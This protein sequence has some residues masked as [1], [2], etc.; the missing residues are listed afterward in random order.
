MI[1]AGADHVVVPFRGAD[2]SRGYGAAVY[3]DT[4][5]HIGGRG[6]LERTVGS[7]KKE[8]NREYQTRASRSNAKRQIFVACSESIPGMGQTTVIPSE[9]IRVQL[10]DWIRPFILWSSS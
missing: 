9:A 5:S 2:N 8:V 1:D 10:F 4:D 3:P 7:Y 6:I